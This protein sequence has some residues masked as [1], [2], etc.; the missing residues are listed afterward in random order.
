M[1]VIG[2]IAEY[3]PFHKGHKYHIDKV[4]EMFPNSII[5]A[6]ISSSFTQ[7]G[8]VSVLNKWDKTSIAIDNGI[9]LVV[10][11]P[12]VYSSQSAD[13]FA[14]GALKILSVLG[15]NKIIFGSECND[16]DKL[17]SV[18]SIQVN[19]KDFNYWV[20]KYLDDGNNYPTSISKA[21]G[22]FNIERLDSPNDLLGISYIKEI[23]KNN[24]NI[25]PFTIKRTNNYHGGNNDI[26][27]S[28][29]EIRDKLKNGISVSN[30]ICYD[31]KLLY[32]NIDYFS[33]L[34]YQIINNINCLSRFNT[35]DEG[36]DNR[37]RKV[38]VS[39]NSL[40]D[41][42]KK[43]KTKRYTYNK[44]NRMFIHILTNLTRDDVKFDIDYVR[45]LGFNDIGKGYLNKIKKSVSIPIITRYKNID[46]PLLDIEMRVTYIYSLIVKD[47]SLIEKELSKPTY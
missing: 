17:F 7:R 42:I 41:L 35:V 2:I 47:K 11:L 28:A 45:V 5:I 39:T 8:D 21:L 43:I 40:D 10:E 30:Y 1:D 13:I 25:T 3:N 15:V 18:A 20:K 37:I 32:R 9:D 31:Q 23:L 26:N 24:Y 16:I 22:K 33:F 38:I 29:S 12:F 46:S 27:I 4:K 6:C 36:I 19:N 34:K 44:I 14:Y